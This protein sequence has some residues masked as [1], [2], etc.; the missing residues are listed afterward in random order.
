[1]LTSAAPASAPL[2]ASCPLHGA[3]A[4]GTCTRCGNFRC[5]ECGEA[6]ELCADCLPASLALYAPISLTKYAVLLVVTCGLYELVWTYRAWKSEMQ[7]SGEVLSPFWRAVFGRIYGFPLFAVIHRQAN[8]AGATPWWNPD[9][10]ALVMLL[11]SIATNFTDWGFVF[12]LLSIVPLLIVQR[13]VLELHALRGGRGQINDRFRRSH[14]GLIVLFALV[15]FV[16]LTGTQLP[17]EADQA[18]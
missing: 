10:M 1:M 5:E 2:P 13:T 16:A 15:V 9:V 4:S 11:C 3:P 12:L 7:R 8:Q 17:P 18:R 6:S 14:W